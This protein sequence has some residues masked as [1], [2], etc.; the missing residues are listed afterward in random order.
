M[1]VY[2]VMKLVPEKKLVMR[3]SDGPF[4]ME[5]TYTW[6]AVDQGKTHMTLRN[7]G[8]PTGNGRPVDHPSSPSSAGLLPEVW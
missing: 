8:N 6:E 2:E 5:T 7:T 3:T 1:Y 4:P